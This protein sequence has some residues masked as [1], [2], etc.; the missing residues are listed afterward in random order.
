MERWGTALR[1]ASSNLRD[2]F[3]VVQTAIKSDCNS[4]RY[5]SDDLRD[6]ELIVY[7]AVKCDGM[8]LRFASK[9]LRGDEQIALVAVNQVIRLFWCTN[10][11]FV[12]ELIIMSFNTRTVSLFNTLE[13]KRC[14]EVLHSLPCLKLDSRCS[15]LPMK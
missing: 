6:Q 1:Y 10:F 9:R 7:D 5:A 14:A 11:L 12:S 3:A 13:E 15:M 4:L 2:D 8:M